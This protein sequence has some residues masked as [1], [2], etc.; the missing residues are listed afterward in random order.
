MRQGSASSA[1]SGGLLV[2]GTTSGAGKSLVTAGLCRWLA[3]NRYQVAPFKAQNMSNNSMLCADGSEIGRAQW[4]QALAAGVVPEAAMNPV[5]LKPGS[6]LRS[7]VTL[8]GKPFGELSSAGWMTD[9]AVLADAAF[10][11][12]DDLR[13]RFDVVIAE[14]AGSPTEINLRANDYVNMGLARHA[15]LPV[16]VVGDIDRGGV[17]AAMFGTLALLSS[18]DQALVAGWVINKFR[19]D[20]GLLSPALE[21]FDGLTGRP[22]LGTLPW[23]DDVW[24]DAEDALAVAGWS[25]A[26][27]AD[28]ETL[29]IAVVRLPR[30]SNTTDVDALAA[31][32][33]VAVS[34]T[35]DP[36]LVST[37]HLVVLP[38]S[39]ATVADLDWLHGRGIADALDARQR[40]GQPILGICA[41]YQMLASTIVDAVESDRGRVRGLGLLPTVVTFRQ[42]RQQTLSADSWRGDPVETYQIHHGDTDLDT[43]DPRS[44][45]VEPFLDG[46]RLAE[47]W[48]TSGH[49]L[50]ENDAFRR[51]WL[52]EIA[53]QAGI[54]WRAASAAPSFRSLRQ[55]MLDRLADAVEQHLDTDRILEL[56]DRGS[57]QAPFIPPGAP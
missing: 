1:V 44:G 11:A 9:R 33:G 41:G 7:H 52:S 3:R 17:F 28:S 12:F 48:G 24:I 37:A 6:D 43:A 36:D 40:K 32:P 27:V 34:V 15:H 57:S 54:K 23:L 55:D 56:I 47:T 4:L 22:V 35:A 5:L 14:G 39:R 20:S 50:F 21:D 51:S 10:H 26:R 49:G 8:L 46:F 18:E 31:E 45:L 25:G 13:S 38:G 42:E 53:G 2:A 16:L 19:G 29:R 30:V